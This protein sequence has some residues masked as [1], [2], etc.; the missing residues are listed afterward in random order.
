MSARGCRPRWKRRPRPLARRIFYWFGASIFATVVLATL[1]V[2]VLGFVFPTEWESD[3][4]RL[5]AHLSR[6]FESVWSRPAERDRIA[7]EIA[8]DFGL[9][10]R[11]E[12]ASGAVLSST[13]GLDCFIGHAH[14]LPLTKHD[15]APLGRLAVCANRR[16]G[17]SAPLKVFFVL[18]V[19]GLVLWVA[20]L[21]IARRV[22]RPLK[23]VTA[24]AE[25]IGHGDLSRR[26]QPVRHQTME[27]GILA[28]AIDEMAARLQRQ[29][30]DQ[31]EL[32]AAVS[33]ELRTPLGHLRILVELVHE[34]QREP[35]R[36]A[37]SLADMEAEIIEIDHLV[38]ELLASSKLDFGVQNARVLRAADVASRALERAG[39]P[40]SL[41]TVED[42][43]TLEADATLLAR[44]L[45]NLL[46]NAA[47]HGGGATVLG[48]SREED[49][50]RF[51]VDDAGPGVAEQ[52]R[53]RIFA[54]LQRGEGGKGALGLGLALVARIAEA[55]Q[56]R[57]FVTSNDA[58]GARF[59]LTVPIRPKVT[60]S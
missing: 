20:S 4:E 57:A 18:A 26:T 52:D 24:V 45:A 21:A 37:K 55:H 14:R 11:I 9:Q 22:T 56:G 44:A 3:G 12:D 27:L 58:G 16:H 39:L 54:P 35:A 47:R 15:G 6:R 2:V 23:D 41:L 10:V 7:S 34:R 13:G 53:E 30:D 38:S 60:P 51:F 49:R 46:D 32:L 25:G 19:V 43:V 29:I 1:S 42:D 36:L 31:R 8:E 50:V 28:A 40:A 5:S 59:V 48:V 17:L 33:H